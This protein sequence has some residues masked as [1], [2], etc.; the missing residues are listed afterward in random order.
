MAGVV[1]ARN[2]TPY[3]N[4]AVPKGFPR[5][6]VPYDPPEKMPGDGAIYG[7]PSPAA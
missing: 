1:G 2:G 5:W 6:G 3:G 7:T 4:A